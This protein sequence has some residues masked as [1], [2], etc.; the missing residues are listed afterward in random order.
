MILPDEINKNTTLFLDRDGVINVRPMDSYIFT[1]DQFVFID[2]VKEALAIFAK[3][4]PRIIVVTNQQ[5]IGKN[6]MTMEDADRVH[7]QMIQL[8]ADAGGRIDKVYVAPQLKSDQSNMRKPNIGMG[9]KAKEYFPDIDFSNSIMVGDTV[10]DISFGKKL[11]MTTVVVGTEYKHVYNLSHAD[12][13][14]DSLG[15]MS[16]IFI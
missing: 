7:A 13:C 10:T 6:L 16:K 8:V 1:P 9:L 12:Y 11:K 2:G 4:F 14:F 5:G 3:L 15:T